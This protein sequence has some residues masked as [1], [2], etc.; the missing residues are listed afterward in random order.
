MMTRSVITGRFTL[1]VTHPIRMIGQRAAAV[2]IDGFQGRVLAVFRRSF[3]VEDRKGVLVCLGEEGIGPGP[4]NALYG[5]PGDE[6]RHLPS[7]VAEG[8]AIRVT[9]RLILVDDQPVF[10]LSKAEPW[11]PESAPAGW[12]IGSLRRGLDHVVSKDDLPIP[13]DG[14]GPLL[15]LVTDGEGR[16]AWLASCPIGRYANDAFVALTEWLAHG[17]PPGQ[18]IQ[19]VPLAVERLVGLG[20]GLTPSGDDFLGGVLI[21]LGMLGEE[22]T[23]RALARWLEPVA[24]NRTGT[25][26]RAHL[27]CAA[28][29]EGASALHAV[30]HAIVAGHAQAIDRALP[31]IASVGHS[32]GW[33]ALAGAATAL[34]AWV[35]AEDHAFTTAA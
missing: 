6:S 34:A 1:P 33:D 28:A 10:D 30:L 26:S 8:G 24:R 23:A 21:V 4:L 16:R 17:V 14:L 9:G 25:I 15:S 29:G 32:S 35:R 3:Y 22:R 7:M 18:P 20:P 27:A 31:G 12:D 2:L 13:R 19:P 11:H 5:W